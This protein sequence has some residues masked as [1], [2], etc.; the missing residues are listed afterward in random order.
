MQIWQRNHAGGNISTRVIRVTDTVFHAEAT[1]LREVLA[2]LN[3]RLRHS[4]ELAEARA[5]E[6]AR[7]Q[8]QHQ[9][10]PRQC[11]DWHLVSEAAVH[12]ERYPLT[13][14]GLPP[15]PEPPDN[16]LVVRRGRTAWADFLL[17]RL[18]TVSEHVQFLWDRRYGERRRQRASVEADRR[19]SD[20]RGPMPPVWNN[21]NFILVYS[22][23]PRR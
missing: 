13:R 15:T 14:P 19:G 5:D 18:G 17:R 10:H 4:L 21:L 1:D 12:G 11:D 9:C 20:R 6:M 3:D 16:V 23:D 22:L 2:T 7:E 8:F